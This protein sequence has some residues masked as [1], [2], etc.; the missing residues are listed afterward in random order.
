MNWVTGEQGYAFLGMEMAGCHFRK[1]LGNDEYNTSK[2]SQNFQILEILVFQI[3]YNLLLL[4]INSIIHQLSI[5][6]EYQNENMNIKIIN[7]IYH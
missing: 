5:Y 1:C 2:K 4:I 7:I 3:H 6:H